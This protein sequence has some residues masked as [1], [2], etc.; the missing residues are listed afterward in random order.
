MNDDVMSAVI[1]KTS[2]DSH[3]HTEW[4]NMMASRRQGKYKA[5][6]IINMKLYDIHKASMHIKT[7]LIFFLFAHGGKEFFFE[8]YKISRCK[9]DGEKCVT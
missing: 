5:I 4:Y 1:L 8:C 9:R 3:C 7:H 6:G 2:N